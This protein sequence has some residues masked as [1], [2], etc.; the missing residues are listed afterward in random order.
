MSVSCTQL[1][2]AKQDSP[3]KGSRTSWKKWLIS[4]LGREGLDGPEMNICFYRKVTMY[5]EMMEICGKGTE[6][7]PKAPTG[8]ILDKL[9]VKINNDS[10]RL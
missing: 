3:L 9:S 8:Q 7:K 5:S 1:L 2:I 6:A 10:N 4:G